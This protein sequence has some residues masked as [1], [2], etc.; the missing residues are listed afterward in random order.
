MPGEPRSPLCDGETVVMRS[1]SR[2]DLI[3]TY[4]DELGFDISEFLPSRATIDLC[5]CE[6]SG[7]EFFHPLNELAGSP[8][9][10]AALY[11]SAGAERGYQEEKWEFEAVAGSL[12]GLDAVLDVGCGAGH[13]LN[14][15][16]G[17]VGALAGLET[18]SYG[19]RAAKEKGLRTFDET[20]GEHAETHGEA[21]DAVTAFQVLEHVA[22]PAAFIAGC[23]KALKPGGTLILS[24]PNND[25]FLRHCDPLA[26]NMPPH[27]V[28]RWGRRSLESLPALFPLELR[29][30][31]YEPLQEANVD[32]YVAVMLR[33]YLPESKIARRLFYRA[34]ADKFVRR[35]VAENRETI[36][37]H[38][39]LASFVRR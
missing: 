23:I 3:K 19:R 34:G 14:S 36:H 13:F 2:A 24:V 7:L 12:A 30:V 16:K 18:S 6:T 8:A 29:R 11:S 9:F 5:R 33:R 28:T 37:G 4:R 39:I 20:I 17:R 26:L 22:D 10:Y 1:L 21:Y 38:T 27:H 35:F 32:W 15:L 31:E 25:S